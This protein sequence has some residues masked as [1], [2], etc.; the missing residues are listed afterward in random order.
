MIMADK[1]NSIS[2]DELRFSFSRVLKAMKAKKKLILTYRR[3]P[4]AIILPY[5]PPVEEISSLDPF[6]MLH[7]SAEPMGSLSSKDIDKELYGF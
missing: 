3:K 6:Y 7:S 4:L 2:T 1:E 5:E